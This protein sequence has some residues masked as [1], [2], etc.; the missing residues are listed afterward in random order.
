MYYFKVFEKKKNIEDEDYILD[1]VLMFDGLY[2]SRKQFNPDDI[3]EIND[4][5][6]EKTG[7]KY[8]RVAIKDFCLLP[9]K[10]GKYIQIALLV[11]NS[12]KLT[13]C[14]GLDDLITEYIE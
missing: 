1:G 8:L 9:E 12:D 7:S 14:S 11:K 3:H 5:L 2:V 10:Y 13:T 6:L 4:F